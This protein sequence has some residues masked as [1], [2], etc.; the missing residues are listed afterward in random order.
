MGA[1]AYGPVRQ[2]A[3]RIGRS[4]VPEASWMSAYGTFATST[5]IRSTTA[6]GGNPDIKLTS[7]QGRV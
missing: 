2:H 3:A 4:T 1:F 6:F 7:P 5:D